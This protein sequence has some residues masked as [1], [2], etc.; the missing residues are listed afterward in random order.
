MTFVPLL[1]SVIVASPTDRSVSAGIGSLA[2]AVSLP[3]ATSVCDASLDASSV[4]VPPPVDPACA[5]TSK[6]AV[7]PDANVALLQSMR[8]PSTPSATGAAQVQPASAATENVVPV[9][10]TRSATNAGAAVPG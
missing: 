9:A 7:A 3:T 10:F 8:W 2:W 5:L 6:C 1:P 4:S